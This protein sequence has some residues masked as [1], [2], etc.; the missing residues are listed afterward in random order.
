MRVNFWKLGIIY[1]NG[2]IYADTDIR[3]IKPI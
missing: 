2:G 1:L 3:P